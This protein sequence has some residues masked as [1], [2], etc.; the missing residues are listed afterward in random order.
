MF[1]VRFRS[2]RV[3]RELLRSQEQDRSRIM[4][5]LKQL[6][7]DARP[8]GIASLDANVYR[9]RVGQF[10]LIYEVDD[11]AQEITVLRIARRNE[12]TYRGLEELF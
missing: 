1:S 12:R 6:A 10:R 7:Q 2:S 5:R 8:Q 4:L 3:E 11:G 9:P